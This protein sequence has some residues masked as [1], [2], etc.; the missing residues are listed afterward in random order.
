MFGLELVWVLL[1]FIVVALYM[2]LFKLVLRC[3]SVVPVCSV[4]FVDVK[5]PSFEVEEGAYELYC[6]LGE[7]EG[8][9]TK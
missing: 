9:A 6:G 1:T 5:D 3:V 8:V 4:R 7:W 2:M